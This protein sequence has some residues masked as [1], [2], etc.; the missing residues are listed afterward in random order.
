MFQVI[1]GGMVETFAFGGDTPYDQSGQSGGD[2]RR[3]DRR[4]RH[5]PGQSV[6]DGAVSI[7]TCD[8]RQLQRPSNVIYNHLYTVYIYMY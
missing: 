3:W 2:R 8:D 6:R 4:D 1:G 7:V 5:R